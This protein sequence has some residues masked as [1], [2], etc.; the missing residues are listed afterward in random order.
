MEFVGS[1]FIKNDLNNNNGEL[2][3]LA[4]IGDS[5]PTTIFLKDHF[6]AKIETPIS[7]MLRVRSEDPDCFPSGLFFNANID[8]SKMTII[9]AKKLSK[10][11]LTSPKIDGG[12][13]GGLEYA[14]SSGVTWKDRGEVNEQDIIQSF[15]LKVQKEIK[16]LGIRLAGEIEF[17]YFGKLWWTEHSEFYIMF[18]LCSKLDHLFR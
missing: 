2:L 11:L 17:Q 16:F 18:R 1:L 9:F 5:A 14:V 15:F 6:L 13:G 7:A 3:A 4:A 8:T 10:F 12:E